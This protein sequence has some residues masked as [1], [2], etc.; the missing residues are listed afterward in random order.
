MYRQLQNC[1]GNLEI[2][3]P[4][5]IETPIEIIIEEQSKLK[6][7]KSPEVWGE[8]FWF[9]VHLGSVNAPEFIPEEKRPFYWG[10]IDGIPE[11]LVCQKCSKHAREWVEIHR[12]YREQICSSRDNLVSFYVDMHNNVNKRNGKPLMTK[13]EVY[14]KF[15]GNVKIKTFRY[16]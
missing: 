6:N 8:S 13:D 15:S 11:M 7:L 2:P 4:I 14:R 3:A 10:F 16:E 1:K 5:K 12:P 9:V